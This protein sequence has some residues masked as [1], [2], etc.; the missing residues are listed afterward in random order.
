MQKRTTT[1]GLIQ[2]TLVG[3]SLV[4]L[5]AGFACAQDAAAPAPSPAAEPA[6]AQ[7]PPIT[8]RVLMKTTLGDIVLAIE[9][10]RAPI[11]AGNFLYYVDTKRLDGCNFYRA[12]K[13]D[14]DGQFGLIQGGLRGNPK[15]VFRPIAHEPTT[16]TGLSHVS[17]A[18]SMAR[19]DPGTATADFFIVLGDVTQF[20][21]HPE[22]NDPGYA[23]F[24]R[25]VEGMDVVRAILDLP[26]SDA[27]PIPAMKGQMLAEPV[28]ILSVRRAD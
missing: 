17:G 19:T 5:C 11:T 27:A 16:L 26:R 18:I 8:V 23:V 15:R 2:R 24:G 1:K 28:K 12:M 25:V 14:D 21:A 3:V 20:D 9:K 13:F 6:P 10:Q 7:P 22:A 4:T